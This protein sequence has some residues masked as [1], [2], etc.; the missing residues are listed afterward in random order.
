MIISK[1]LLLLICS[2]TINNIKDKKEVEMK[3]EFTLTELI[4]AVAILIMVLLVIIS[5]R[6]SFIKALR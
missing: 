6:E 5:A 4:I 2:L 1:K 3:K